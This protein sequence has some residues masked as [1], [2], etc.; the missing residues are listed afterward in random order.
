MYKIYELDQYH[1]ITLTCHVFYFMFYFQET[2]WYGFVAYRLETDDR[3]LQEEITVTV[4][5]KKE[6][7]DS[8]LVIY[9]NHWKTKSTVM[10]HL[11]YSQ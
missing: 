2:C 11:V 7:N 9:S 6:K 8:W 4:I 3:W 1:K 10:G 5:W